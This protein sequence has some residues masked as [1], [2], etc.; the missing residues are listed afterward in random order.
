MGS[1]ED[2]QSELN[3]NSDSTSDGEYLDN[4]ILIQRV[5]IDTDTG[6]ARVLKQYL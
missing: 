2:I 6:Y 4:S 5:G 1:D 3:N